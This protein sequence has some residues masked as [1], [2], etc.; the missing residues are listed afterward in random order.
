[1]EYNTEIELEKKIVM[2]T[3]KTVEFLLSKNPDALSL[4]LFYIKNAKIQKTNSIF[5]VES[6]GMKGMG[7]GRDRYRKA[8]QILVEEGFIEDI[9]RK[10]EKGV[11]DGHFLKI[12]YMFTENTL[13]NTTRQVSHPVGSPTSGFQETNALSNTTINALSNK[14][15]TSATAESEIPPFKVKEIQRPFN[16]E[17]EL[18][19]LVISSWKPNKIIALFWKRKKWRFENKAQWDTA[20]KRQ[21]KSARALEGYNS[22]QLT[23]GMEYCEDNH[24]QL[25]WG[26]ETLIKVMPKIINDN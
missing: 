3:T 9:T 21:L 15:E 5:N 22:E 7:W 8:K 6:F 24:Y 2:L 18:N 12:N 26:L 1:M 20:Y 4:Y 14:K 19:K 13:K 17:N 16:F 10:N 11:I 23:K 25:N